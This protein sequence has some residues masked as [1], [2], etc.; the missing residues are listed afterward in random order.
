[1]RKTSNVFAFSIEQIVRVSK[2]GVGT[3]K[4]DVL[5]LAGSLEINHLSE[6]N[7]LD[8]GAIYGRVI[9]INS[10]SQLLLTNIK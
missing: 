10:R 6:A 8:S 7:F 4:N 9:R 2:T 5:S 1:M 3:G